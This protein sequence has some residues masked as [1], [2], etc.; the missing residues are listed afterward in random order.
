MRDDLGRRLMWVIWPAFLVAAGADA[1]FFTLFDPVDLRLFGS[2]LDISR[3]AFYTLGFFSFWGLG[4]ASSAL[5]VFLGRSPFEA[6]RGSPDVP[7]RPRDDAG[8]D[9]ADRPSNHESGVRA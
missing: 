2:P 3:A 1:V 6:D 8:R 9:A 7:T 5:T 4:V